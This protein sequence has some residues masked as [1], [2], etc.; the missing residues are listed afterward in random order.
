MTTDITIPKGVTIT[1][2]SSIGSII[3]VLVANYKGYDKTV[4]LLM[5]GVAG[6]LVGVLI[7]ANRN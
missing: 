1:L 4:G 2:A 3:G 5:G 7:E 6:T